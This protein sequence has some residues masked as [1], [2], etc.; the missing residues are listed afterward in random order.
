M[1]VRAVFKGLA[2]A[3]WGVS[4]EGILTIDRKYDPDS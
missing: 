2:G 4:Q 1:R 3:G